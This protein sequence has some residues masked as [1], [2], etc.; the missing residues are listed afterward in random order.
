MERTN[1]LAR[2]DQSESPRLSWMLISLFVGGVAFIACSHL[3]RFHDSLFGEIIRDLGIALC[4]S[5]VIALIIE[6]S[7]SRHTFLR[8]LDAIMQ[9][10]VPP[11]VWEEFR[12]HVITQ[13]MMRENWSLKMSLGQSKDGLCV[14]DTAVKYTIV[15][16]Q[17]ALRTHV[18]HELDSHRT[19]PG[20]ATR[21]S[22]AKIG[23]DEYVG[24]AALAGANVLS[25]GGLTLQLPVKLER[26]DQTVPVELEFI[27]TVD[28]PDIIIWWMG[29][30]TRNVTLKIEQLPSS[31]SVDVQTYHPAP[32]L[33]VPTGNDNEWSFT[34]VMLP[35]QGVE[36]RIKTTC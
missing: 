24:A 27:E 5:V 34:G 13:P 36:I 4:I 16:L 17:D 8:G 19:P 7:L 33:L 29:R 10:T 25:N 23:K 18:R 31:W 28:C 1:Q 21:Y 15:G 2:V 26:H 35:G 11:D 9:R 22:R 30:V 32:H 3:S 12:Q 14:S 6:L 20:A